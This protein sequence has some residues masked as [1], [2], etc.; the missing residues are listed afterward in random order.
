MPRMNSVDRVIERGVRQ[1][2]R[3]EE[4]ARKAEDSTPAVGEV[5]YDRARDASRALAR[6]WPGMTAE[7]KQAKIDEAGGVAAF[8]EFMGKGQR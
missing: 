3:L 1:L 4:R 8:M 6:S 5:M 2:A 7:E